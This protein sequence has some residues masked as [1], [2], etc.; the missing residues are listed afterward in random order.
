MF[1]LIEEEATITIAQ[2]DVEEVNGS[3]SDGTQ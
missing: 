2:I 3:T 1:Q